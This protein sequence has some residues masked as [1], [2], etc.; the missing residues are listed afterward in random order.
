MYA[1]R[2][3]YASS[4]YPNRHLL[5]E[6]YKSLVEQLGNN[7]NPKNIELTR[8]VVGMV[9]LERKLS[10]KRRVLSLMGDRV[11]QVKRQAFHFDLLADNVLSNIASIYS[12]HISNL[13][14]RIQA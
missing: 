12:D 1:I 14:P 13:G 8:Y 7:R 11:G 4:V 6:G 2:S 3:Y 5:R 9:A 10:N